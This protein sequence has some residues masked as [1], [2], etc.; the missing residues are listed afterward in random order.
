MSLGLL[1]LLLV[2]LGL[3]AGVIQMAPYVAAEFKKLILWVLLVVAIVITANFFGIL[4][5][6]TRGIQHG[7][8]IGGRRN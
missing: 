4:E 2:G 8:D 3:L 1:L 7:L 5:P 6:F